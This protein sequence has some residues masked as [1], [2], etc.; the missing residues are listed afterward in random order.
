MGYNPIGRQSNFQAL[1]GEI[2]VT[3]SG[4]VSSMLDISDNIR[5]SYFSTTISGTSNNYVLEME[6]SVNG[7][8][9]GAIPDTQLQGD[10]VI[11]NIQTVARYV[12]V[13]VLVGEGS[14]SF[15][16]CTIVGK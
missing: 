1:E 8:Q 12:R 11:D 4:T 5:A 2:D 15:T 3:V 14:P 9:W 6:C 16:K 13:K 7:I 10:G